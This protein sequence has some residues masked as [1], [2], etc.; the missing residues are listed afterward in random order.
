MDGITAAHTRKDIASAEPVKCQVASGV[1]KE[2]MPLNPG[3][4]LQWHYSIFLAPFGLA[5]MLLLLSSLRLGHHGAHAGHGHAAIH[6]AAGTHVAVPHSH[7]GNIAGTHPAHHAGAHHSGGGVRHGHNGGRSGAK[8]SQPTASLLASLFGI[9]RAPLPMIVEAFFIVWGLAGCL[10]NQ[11][12]LKNVLAPT[13]IQAL[14]SI[15]IAAGAG[16]IGARLAVELIGR[17]MPEEESLIVSREG[18]FGLKGKVAFPVSE[19]GG[20]I[21]VYDDFGSLHDETCRVAPGHSSI[22]RGKTVMVMDRDREGRLLVEEIV[23]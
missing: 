17:L 2:G 21:I 11:F 23:E 16:L 14:P 5:A 18:L 19:V 4:L 10:A 15:G 20:R 9:G 8:E 22:E 12:L 6:G 1:G 7:G 3:V 13:L